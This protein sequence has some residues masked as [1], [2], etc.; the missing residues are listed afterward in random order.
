M[1]HDT[2]RTTISTVGSFVAV[3]SAFPAAGHG[4]ENAIKLEFRTILSPGSG[5]DLDL[6]TVFSTDRFLV[7]P[8]GADPAAFDAKK[9]AA[10]CDLVKK[11]VSE[12]PQEAKR[13]L[14]IFHGERPDIDKAFAIVKAAGLTEDAAVKAGGGLIGLIVLLIVVVAAAGCAHTKPYKKPDPAK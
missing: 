4:L 8:L 12:R 10:D 1:K 14:Q 11:F 7:D 5:Q 13:L 6:E 2:M 9:I 3:P